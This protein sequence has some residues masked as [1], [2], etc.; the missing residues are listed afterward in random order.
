MLKAEHNG[1]PVLGLLTFIIGLP[2]WLMGC[3]LAENFQNFQILSFKRIY[4]LRLFIIFIMLVLQII[5]FHAP[6]V[7]ASNCF[8]LN[9][10]A[11]LGTYWLGYEIKYFIFNKPNQIF[12][13]FGKFS[14]SLYLIH[15]LVP[16]IST[17]FKFDIF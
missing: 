11:I 8:T 2:C 12:E 15:V 6:T 10:F 3:W 4:I 17:Y 14:Y 9:L 1:Y 7:F 16:S 13:Y 5:K